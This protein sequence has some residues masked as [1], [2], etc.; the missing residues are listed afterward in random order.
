MMVE[1]KGNSSSPL[2][3]V[4]FDSVQ[5]LNRTTKHEF[6]LYLILGVIWPERRAA[7]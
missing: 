4:E 2:D 3:V 7:S 6:E 1:V 5:S